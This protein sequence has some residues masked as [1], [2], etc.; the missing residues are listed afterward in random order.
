MI[1]TRLQA[2]RMLMR[3]LRV[4][5]LLVTERAHVRYLTGFSG[6]CGI[7][8]ITSTAQF[9]L[10]DRRYRQQSY[11]E[12]HGFKILIA[13]QQLFSPLI[14]NKLLPTYSRIGYESQYIS[15]AELQTLRKL[16]PRRQ[17]I[18]ANNII[19]TVS[20][21]KDENEVDLIRQAAAI[22]DRVFKKL[23]PLIRPGVREC[24]IAAEISYWH[25]TYGAECDSFEPIVASGERGALPHARAS[26][27]KIQR[28][29]FVV[30]DFGC[31]YRGYHSDMTRTLAVGR[32]SH[33]MKGIY[34]I[35]FDAQKKA[36]DAI[37]AGVT[38]RSIDSI[39]RKH[40]RR[41]GYGRYFFHSLGHGLGI[42][43]HDPLRVST[44]SSAHLVAGNVL[45]IEPGIYLPGRGGVR[46]EDDVVVRDSGCEML[47]HA[48]KE[49]LIV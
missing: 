7:C 46:I 26:E 34:R 42:H 29:E 25:R 13:Q 12:V 47:T 4:S 45:A 19:E 1:Q 31:R 17:F 22:S 2:V 14:E 3:T 18:P 11:Q 37:R 24:D 10:T 20:A 21:V 40:I 44:R 27:K 15:V 23:L 41:R 43:V 32:P 48:P 28:G 16:L 39:A 33:L 38:A 35:V 49:L 36:L 9:F 8:L 5:S 30:L 6:T